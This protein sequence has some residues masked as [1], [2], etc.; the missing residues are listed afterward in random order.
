MSR[1]PVPGDTVV[2]TSVPAGLLNN[3]PDSDQRA[4]E[5]IVGKPVLLRDFDDV[6]RAELEFVDADGS[7]HVIFVATSY[8]R[9]SEPHT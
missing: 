3:L 9:L 2:L 4:I 6:G 8:I 5:N 1:E 7:F